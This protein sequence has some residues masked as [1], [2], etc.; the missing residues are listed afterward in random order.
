[1]KIYFLDKGPCRTSFTAGAT[2]NNDG[3]LEFT[4]HN[5]H[6]DGRVT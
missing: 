6:N 5:L 1:M 4:V 2:T 3:I